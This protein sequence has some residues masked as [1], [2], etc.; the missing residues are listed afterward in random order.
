MFDH[1]GIKVRDLSASTRFYRAALEPLGFVFDSG[2]ATSCGFGPRGAAA[3]YLYQSQAV[4][5]SA[6][7]HVALV[8]PSREA[9]DRFYAAGIEAGGRDNGKPGVRPSYSPTYYAAFL[10]DPDGNNLEAVCMKA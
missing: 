5:T 6:A 7:T 2:D 1:I 10:I 9:V 3:L 4:Q 8:A